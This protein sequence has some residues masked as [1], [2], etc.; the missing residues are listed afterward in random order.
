MLALGSPQLTGKPVPD[1]DVAPVISATWPANIE[2][3]ERHNQPGRFTTFIAYEYSSQPAGANLHRNVIFASNQVPAVPFGAGNGNPE[4]LWRWMDVQRL[5]GMEALAIPHN[6]NW[7]QGLMFERNNQA[8]EPIDA[9]YAEQRVRIEPLV[10]ITQVK[11]TS[12]THPVLSPTDEW[13]DFE[14]WKISK[15]V[16]T[17]L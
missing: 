17:V 7:S 10:E 9:G 6:A 15:F 14:I 1:L 5:G 3:A 11:G 12:E 2:A 13:A 4:D 16:I 8:G